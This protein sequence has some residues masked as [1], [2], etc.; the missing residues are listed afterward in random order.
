[1]K[2]F[3]PDWEETISHWCGDTVARKLGNFVRKTSD[4]I[5]KGI[6]T[7]ELDVSEY[8]RYETEAVPDKQEMNE[9]FSR[10]EAIRH[11]VERLK[12]RIARLG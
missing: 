1:M 11:D 4:A 7:F 8:L 9:F 3:E 10:V 2:G 12:M 5:Q 6:N